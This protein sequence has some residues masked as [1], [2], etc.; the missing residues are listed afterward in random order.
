MKMLKVLGLLN[1]NGTLSLTNLRVYFAYAILGYGTY[2]GMTPEQLVAILTFFANYGLKRFTQSSEYKK[3]MEQKVQEKP[4][5]TDV[6]NL[7]LEIENLKS[8]VSFLRKGK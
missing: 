6:D 5:V 7:K 1:D 4:E 3:Q 2:S 8:V